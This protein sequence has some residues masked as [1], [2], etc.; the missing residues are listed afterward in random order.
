[1]HHIFMDSEFPLILDYVEILIALTLTENLNH[2]HNN[3]NTNSII[4]S[5]KSCV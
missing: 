5:F 4:M 1:M 2:A 3:E